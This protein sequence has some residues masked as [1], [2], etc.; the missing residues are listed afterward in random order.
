MSSSESFPMKHVINKLDVRRPDNN[1]PMSHT[2]FFILDLPS[3]SSP[4]KLHD[5]LLYAIH[6]CQDIDTDNTGRARAAAAA[7]RQTAST[8]RSHRYP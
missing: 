3:Y 7:S 5:R 6:N 4:E 8:P 2:C 1:Y